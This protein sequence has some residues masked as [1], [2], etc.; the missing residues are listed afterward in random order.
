MNKVQ[1]YLLCAVMILSLVVS[2]LL[3]AQVHQ[4]RLVYASLRSDLSASTESWKQTN[5]EKLVLQKEL[6]TVKDELREA[7]MTLEEYDALKAE[8]E[9]LEKEVSVLKADN[10]AKP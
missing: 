1:K 6:K 7:R 4:S 8:V 9:A 5:E 3:G 10:P 2:V